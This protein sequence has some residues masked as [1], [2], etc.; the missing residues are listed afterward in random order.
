MKK[1]RFWILTIAVLL[2]VAFLGY[3]GYVSTRQARLLKQARGYLARS[4]PK[5]ALV[6]LR[7]ALGYNPKDVEACRLMA[8]LAERGSS[9]A[10][11]LWRSRV[12]EL[13]P[14]S[15]PDRIFLAQTAM[16]FGDY[17]SA[18]NA[19]EG[20][21]KTGRSTAA[22]HNAAGSVALAARN[23]PEAETHFFEACQIEPT[24]PAPRMNLAIVRLQSTNTFALVQ[25]R[26]ALR[27]L[28]SDPV[29]RSQALRESTQDAMRH[30]QGEEALIF[31]AELIRETNHVFSD[32]LLRLDVLRANR[33]KEFQSSLAVLESDAAKDSRKIYELVIWQS[34]TT[35]PAE[36]L[37]WLQ[38]LPIETQTNQPAA[39]L[40]A[41]CRSALCDWTGLQ[42]S[43]RHQNWTELEF[44]RHAYQSLS[45]RGQDLISSSSI[46]WQKA[47]TAA[48]NRKEALL[49]LY[50][51][52]TAWNWAGQKEELLWALIRNY[53]TEKWATA[54]LTKSLLIEGR[55]RSLMTLYNQ[56]MNVNPSDLSARNNLAMTALLL[57]AWELRPH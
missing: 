11:M 39:L 44:I 16:M 29:L 5:T 43:L 50:R 23:F 32:E 55:T 30:Q 3:Y 38:T 9:P 7:R 52:A 33:D 42:A 27:A 46:E 20:I 28:R 54:A 13:A 45:L 36:A 49:M 51:L 35:G 26:A 21:S 19:L 40:A 2:G 8:E 24:N 41:Q 18:T 10:A 53:P 22:Y 34:A 47:L 14:K 57:G 15:T 48:K 12:V 56:Q 37:N 25:A 6:C 1:Q 31:A 17:I 4:N